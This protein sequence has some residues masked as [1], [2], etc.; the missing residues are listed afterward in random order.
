MLTIRLV[1]VHVGPKHTQC[2]KK[3]ARLS[4]DLQMDLEGHVQGLSY[5][6]DAAQVFAND[7][8]FRTRIKHIA[9]DCARNW[10]RI[11]RVRAICILARANTDDNL[12]DMF[13]TILTAER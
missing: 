9:S 13:T 10:V 3:T 8:C 1:M 7:T 2:D 6:N 11:L 4:P 12:A 5:S